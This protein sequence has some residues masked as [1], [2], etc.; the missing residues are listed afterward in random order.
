MNELDLL[1]SIIKDIK[2]QIASRKQGYKIGGNKQEL[3]SNGYKINIRTD[4]SGFVS[5]VISC[6]RKKNISF[7]TYDEVSTLTQNGFIALSFPGWDNLK[8]GDI[9]LKDTHTEFFAYNENGKHYVWNCGSDSSCNTPGVTQSYS[10]P[11]HTILRLNKGEIKMSNSPLVAYTRLSPNHSGSRKNKISRITPH[12]IVGQMGIESL[13]EWFSKSSTRAS[14]NYGIGFDGRV[15]MYVEEK[16]R[17]WTSS[18]SD[19]DNKAV[20]IECASELKSPFAF[21]D[22]VFDSL[23]KLCIDICKRNGKNKLIWP[24]SKAATL[25]YNPKDN[26]MLLTVHRYFS[27]TACFPIETELFTK[28][29]WKQIKDINI[30]DEVAAITNLFN[31]KYEFQSVYD[32]IDEREEE[33]YRLMNGITSTFDHRMVYKVENGKYII[34]TFENMVKNDIIYMPKVDSINDI[35]AI[36][37]KE[38]VKAGIQGSYKTKVSCVSVPSGIILI[39]QNGKMFI[40]GNCPGDWLMS[41]LTKLCNLVNEGL[42]SSNNIQ[43]FNKNEIVMY[44]GDVHYLSTTSISGNKC[45]PGLAKVNSYDPKGSH[46]YHLIGIKGGSGVY[47]W[48]DEKN[49][50]KVTQEKPKE[51]NTF[52]EYI[53]KVKTPY[54]NIR[55]GP[56]TNFATIGKFTGL[57]DFTII[58]E[59]AGQG[60]DKWGLLKSGE[61]WI[62][63]NPTYVEKI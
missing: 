57:G 52:K 50:S 54:L 56:G 43:K 59:S 12:C 60:A 47:G 5:A 10:G 55:K 20:T 63:L 25:L 58:K 39:R 19:N 11:Y 18:S 30:G 14:S 16:N 61:G 6:L 2:K 49:I 27:N 31:F 15:G 28:D 40:T 32:K 23:V 44:N 35:N 51:E 36:V 9:L 13:G 41:K 17:A 45:K 33:V 38:L 48:V 8:Q 21:K 42:G 26:E 4:C 46:N 53:V 3:S 22:V 37:E 1:V 62:A 34:D 24:G 29:G 7:S